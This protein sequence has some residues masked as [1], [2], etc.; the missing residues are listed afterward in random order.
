MQEVNETAVE[1]ALHAQRKHMQSH[2]CTAA[3]EHGR[4]AFPSFEVGRGA[5]G[6]KQV[7]PVTKANAGQARIS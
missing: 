6:P 5:Q 7:V 1:A 2:A 4:A 3:Y